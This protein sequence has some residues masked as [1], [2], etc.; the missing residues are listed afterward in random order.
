MLTKCRGVAAQKLLAL[1]V[2]SACILAQPGA[3]RAQQSQTVA[4][5]EKEGTVVVYGAPGPLY[6]KVLVDTF[7]AAFPKI[8]VEYLGGRGTDEATKMLQEQNA[9]LY[10]VDVYISGT[11][12]GTVALKPA[13]AIEPLPP[14]LYLPEVIDKNAWLDREL[15]WADAKEPF[16]T[17]MFECGISQIV[18]INPKLVDGKQFTSYWDLLDSKWKGKLVGGDIRQPGPGGVPSR[19]IYKNPKLGPEFL[20]KLFRDTD[21]TL[22][23]DQ[24][25]LIDWIALGKFPMG[26]FVSSSFAKLAEDQGLPI[27]SLPVEQFKEGG[28]I[29]PGYGAVSIVTKAPHPHA[30]RLY[31]NWVLSRE[32]QTAWQKLAARPSCRTDIGREGVEQDDIPKP[33]FKYLKV[34]AEEYSRLT[35]SIISNVVSKALE[36]RE[37]KR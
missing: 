30:A 34:G 15:Q 29:G 22:S 28:P 27:K 21:I 5:A 12:N 20:T 17:L 26:I 16:T 3:S 33:G 7:Q 10:N 35:G 31:I 37:K 18:Y 24:R 25:Q 1:A 13:R 11:T 14:V 32:G 6:R 4:A 23:S 9:G 19:F 2:L 8:R 36:Q